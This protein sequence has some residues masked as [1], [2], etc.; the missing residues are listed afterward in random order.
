MEITEQIDK[1][2]LSISP[3]YKQILCWYKKLMI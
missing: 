1:R 3:L 2:A